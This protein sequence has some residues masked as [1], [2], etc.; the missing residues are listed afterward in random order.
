MA[1]I[2]VCY[3]RI[4]CPRW[5]WLS[6]GIRTSSILS[7]STKI[8]S[9]TR[10]RNVLA[11]T[12]FPLHALV[13]SLNAQY[14]LEA[15]DAA[16]FWEATTMLPFD[17]LCIERHET[18]ALDMA[19][20]FCHVPHSVPWTSIV[21]PSWTTKCSSCMKTWGVSELLGFRLVSDLEKWADGGDDR[22]GFR[23]RGGVLS[24]KDSRYFLHDPFEPVLRRVLLHRRTSQ[25]DME[26]MKQGTLV[27]S[28]KYGQI[29]MGV[30]A[31]QDMG[32]MFG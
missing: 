8:P 21:S 9:V 20:P 13:Q 18:N 22:T 6:F 26:S 24:A 28:D 27:S 23:L 15:P 14:H 17:P 32:H 19:C 16:A 25:A 1:L 4:C 5:T 3:L 31:P 29:T 10:T 12:P 11:I 30:M 7:A 2:P